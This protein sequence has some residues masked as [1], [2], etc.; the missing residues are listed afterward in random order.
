VD[1]DLV[2]DL[3]V[4]LVEPR[5]QQRQPM[6]VGQGRAVP[7][8][9]MDQPAAGVA[10]GA[11]LGLDLLGARRR[12]A[13]QAGVR[14]DVPGAAVAVGQVQDQA[15]VGPPGAGIAGGGRLGLLQVRQR[16][17]M[18]GLAADMDLGPGGS[19]AVGGQVVALVQGRGVAFGALVVPGLV[20]RRPS[21]KSPSMVAALGAAMAWS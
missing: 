16:R 10:A 20:R 17:S 11:E 15:L 9:V 14:V 18:A 2:Q 8:V 1:E 19:I 4:G 13:G 7:V 21:S 5:C 3:T 6:G 12:A